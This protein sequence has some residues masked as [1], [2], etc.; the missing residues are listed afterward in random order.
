MKRV[1]FI[2]CGNMGEAFLKGIINSLMV[3]ISNI[4]VYDLAKG[5]EIESKYGVK[6]LEGELDLVHNSDIIFLAVKPNIY[7]DV[8]DK[9]KDSI[10]SSKILVAMAPGITMEDILEETENRNSKIVRTMPNLPLM[11]QEGCIAYSFNENLEDEEKVFFKELFEKME[12]KSVEDNEKQ[13]NS[14]VFKVKSEKIKD[15]LLSLGFNLDE[16]QMEEDM[17]NCFRLKEKGNLFVIELFDDILNKKASGCKDIDIYYSEKMI[18]DNKKEN[19]RLLKAIFEDIGYEYK[20]IVFDKLKEMFEKKQKDK[21]ID[22]KY[23]NKIQLEYSWEGDEIKLRIVANDF[24]NEQE[25]TFDFNRNDVWDKLKSEEI[26]VSEIKSKGELDFV[27]RM[28]TL[29]NKV[30]TVIIRDNQEKIGKETSTEAIYIQTTLVSLK[31][32]NG[33][34]ENCRILGCILNMVCNNISNNK[35]EK[36]ILQL[37]E[38]KNDN[39]S[40]EIKLED[41]SMIMNNNSGKIEISIIPE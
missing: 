21:S 41:A 11:V 20:S 27:K 12:M 31:D 19:K 26:V 8:I 24:A 7:F 23:N 32:D 38:L 2:G 22:L 30:A 4:S 9:I 36:Y 28:L 37:K 35:I 6:A 17:K 18:R 25:K 33:V 5:K 29:K 14:Y 3:E 13:N 10:N 39:A 16:E 15:N 34:L 1:G 40:K